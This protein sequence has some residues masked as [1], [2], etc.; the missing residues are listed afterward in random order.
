MKL[1]VTRRSKPLFVSRNR[2]ISS[3]YPANIYAGRLS[4]VVL[5]PSTVLISVLMASRPKSRLA[6]MG[7]SWYASS[8]SRVQPRAVLT[9]LVV[10]SAV[11]PTKKNKLN[12]YLWIIEI[13]RGCRSTT[14]F[15]QWINV[16]LLPYKQCYTTSTNT[17]TTSSCSE[18][19]SSSSSSSSTV[20]VILYVRNISHFIYVEVGG[21]NQN[22]P[23]SFLEER[24]GGRPGRDP[25][26]GGSNP[27]NPPGKSDPV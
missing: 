9:T 17:T 22:P 27:P 5:D 10:L 6:S 7:T 23:T 4:S 19:S 11:S 1:F 18:S 2:S 24:W 21:R 8:I 25:E 20:V 13:E 3:G 26:V 15:L 12:S 16:S 14:K